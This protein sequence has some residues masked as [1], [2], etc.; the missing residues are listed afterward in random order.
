M[1]THVI[2]FSA[3]WG[4]AIALVGASY[5][6]CDRLLTVFLLTVAVGVNGAAW[7]CTFGPVSKQ[8]VH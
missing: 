7:A 2:I 4:P 6:G 5:S 8:M 1:L 3:H